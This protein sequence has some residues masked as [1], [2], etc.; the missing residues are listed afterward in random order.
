[1]LFLSLLSPVQ[2]AR[3]STEAE[4]QGAHRQTEGWVRRHQEEYGGIEKSEVEVMRF[5]CERF[6]F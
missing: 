1:M 6:V 4:T 2:E 3:R 5:G